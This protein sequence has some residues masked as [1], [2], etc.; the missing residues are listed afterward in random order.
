MGVFF[1]AL[2]IGLQREN[3]DIVLGL[4]SYKIFLNEI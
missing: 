4:A 2:E 1:M 3:I